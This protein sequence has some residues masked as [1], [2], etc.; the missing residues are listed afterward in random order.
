MHQ[1][2][3]KGAGRTIKAQDGET[4]LQAAQRNG[5]HID[6]SCGGNGSCHQC[7]V[8]IHEG[9]AVRQGKPVV[10]RHKRGDEPVYL[11]CQCEVHG[12]M[13]IEPAPIE[14]LRADHPVA[15]LLGWNV[16]N[17]EREGKP[18]AVYHQGEY[19]GGAY[20][21]AADGSIESEQGFVALFARPKSPP[22][23]TDRDV[24]VVEDHYSF[25]QCVAAGCS[26]L[27]PGPTAVLD[28]S[29]QIVDL[30]ARSSDKIVTNAFLGSRE[31]MEGAID[32]VEWSPLKTR[33]VIS[34]VGNATPT[35]LSASGVMSCV[36]A[37]L[38]AGMC[39]PDLQLTESRFTREVDGQRVAM[40]VG[41]D[42]EAQTVSG[43]V[44]TSE[45]P[46]VV[47]QGQLN[48]IRDAA[49]VIAA[50]L[51][52]FGG[53]LVSTGEFGT[54]VPD[55]LI[56]ALGIWN[57]EIEFVPHAAA[58]GAARLAFGAATAP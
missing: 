49:A 45:A 55:E 24:V 27:K 42:D 8:V 47:G 33:T 18:L 41:P 52:E 14:T 35:G 23:F 1:V 37:L 29:G 16:G 36:L 26:H 21:V 56:R 12:D 46:I 53:T 28:F 31:H 57:R 20:A 50:K 38:Q 13:V 44:H 54:Y 15:S 39:S 7:R 34:T 2:T 32:Y 19:T 51:A 10:A 4:L 17:G 48:T 5:M 9:E 3:F 25:V 58:L 30:E 11:A 6:S 40:I 43:V 22:M